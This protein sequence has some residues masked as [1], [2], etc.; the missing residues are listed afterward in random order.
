M[1][2]WTQLHTDIQY[3]ICIPAN[4]IVEPEP[5]FL[6]ES[7]FLVRTLNSQINGNSSSCYTIAKKSSSQ[8]ETEINIT[9]ITILNL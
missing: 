1:N 6:L 4:S 5:V 8:L 3:S 9:E 2:T 7:D